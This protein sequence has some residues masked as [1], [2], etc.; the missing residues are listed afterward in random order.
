[1]WNWSSE[2]RKSSN[3][4]ARNPSRNDLA[5][6]VHRDNATIDVAAKQSVPNATLQVSIWKTLHDRNMKHQSGGEK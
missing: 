2:P 3:T 1:M 5:E 6:Q 4:R